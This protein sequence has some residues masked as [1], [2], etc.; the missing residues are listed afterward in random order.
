M[1]RL[2]REAEEVRTPDIVL[3]EVARKYLR[4]E[5]DETRIKERLETIR[6]ASS[7]VPIDNAVAF[8]A[9]KAFL[10]LAE[11]AKKERGKSPGLF[12][13]IVLATAR[14]YDSRIITGDEHLKTLPETIS[15]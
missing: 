2:I 1:K 3:A 8:Q 10:E 4:E 11:K 6:S 14:V 9:G 5:V 7:I 13:A 12:D 15:I